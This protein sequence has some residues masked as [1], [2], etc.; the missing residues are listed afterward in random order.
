M[1]L[2]VKRTFMY[3]YTT[4]RYTPSIVSCTQRVKNGRT[5]RNAVYGGNG[6]FI[7]STTPEFVFYFNDDEKDCIVSID[8]YN[9]V[10]NSMKG[11]RLTENKRDSLLKEID[12]LAKAGPIPAINEFIV[13]AVHNSNI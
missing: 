6:S 7:C 2:E 10:R 4:Y 11:E 12:K 8:A 1:K 9:L 3:T 13:K 5:P